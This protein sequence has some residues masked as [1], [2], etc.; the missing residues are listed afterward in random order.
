MKKLLALFLLLASPAWGQVGFGGIIPGPGT[1]HSAGA[2]YTG[3]G[4][5]VGSAVGWWGLRAYSAAYATALGNA[6]EICTAADALCTVIHVTAT[7]GLNAADITT[8]TCTTTCTIKTLYDQSGNGHN[9]TKAV[10]ASRPT[11]LPSGVSAGK[12]SIHFGTGSNRELAC[13]S[14]ATTTVPWTTVAVALSA[15]NP[16][17][18]ERVFVVNDPNG[19]LVGAGN[20][21]ELYASSTTASTVTNSNSTFY[22]IVA[23][24]DGTG[25]GG[26]IMV[27]GTLTSGLAAGSNSLASP[28]QFGAASSGNINGEVCEGGY[29][30]S[31][32]SA[33]NTTSMNNNMQ[34]YWG[35]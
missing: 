15:A 14:V 20:H 21:W 34:T 8:S 31:L 24:T 4:D 9:C 3:P 10:E 5:V 12:P 25:S 22:A 30:G 6:V 35:I 29:W 33:G 16:G 18:N 27:S 26:K 17:G 7:G 1:V 11:F 23:G 2:S 13:A 32:L 19:I 28:G